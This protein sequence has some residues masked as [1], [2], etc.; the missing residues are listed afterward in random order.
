MNTLAVILEAPERIALRA[1]EMKAVEA[2]DVVVQI[3]YS[4]ISTGTEKLLFTGRMPPFPGLGY[5][6]VPG[7]ES[8][9]RIID[10]GAEARARRC[11]NWHRART[12]SRRSARGLLP[13]RR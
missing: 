11:S 5:P 1:L 8:V 10:A 7:Y 6:L 4:G 13:R 9:G 2:S 3:A 12:P